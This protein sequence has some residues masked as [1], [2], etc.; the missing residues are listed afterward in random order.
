MKKLRV[1]CNPVDNPKKFPAM[2]KY[3]YAPSGMGPVKYKQAIMERA[4]KGGFLVYDVQ[5]VGN[6]CM[7]MPGAE[8][9]VL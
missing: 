2:I 4:Q 6:D 8:G 1:V 7:N 9:E 3:F 5:V